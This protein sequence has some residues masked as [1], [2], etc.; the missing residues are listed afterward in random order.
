M[1]IFFCICL[2]FFCVAIFQRKCPFLSQ[3]CRTSKVGEG[4]KSFCT[5]FWVNT[6]QK[7]FQEELKLV[8]YLVGSKYMQGIK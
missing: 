4:I 7:I 5:N 6:E 8:G 1:F 3:I 2:F